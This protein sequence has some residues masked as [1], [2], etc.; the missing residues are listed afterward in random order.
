M[1]EMKLLEILFWWIWASVKVFL[2]LFEAFLLVWR[3]NLGIW[4]GICFFNLFLII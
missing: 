1:R 3:M 4:P 2:G